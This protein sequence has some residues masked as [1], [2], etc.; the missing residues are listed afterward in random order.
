MSFSIRKQPHHVVLKERFL[1]NQRKITFTFGL[2]ISFVGSLL[3][4]YVFQHMQLLQLV[5]QKEMLKR[6]ILALE[7][8]YDKYHQEEV[9]LSSLQRIEFIAREQLRMV[10]PAGQDRIYLVQPKQKFQEAWQKDL[11]SI[12]GQK[13]GQ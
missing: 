9:M 1:G 10:S 6:K 11:D 3:F 5:N 13:F 8:L 12:T 4:F 2:T 7:K